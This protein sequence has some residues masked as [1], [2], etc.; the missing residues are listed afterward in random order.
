M[1]AKLV[2]EIKELACCGS[3]EAIAVGEALKDEIREE[4]LIKLACKFLGVH[5]L[6]V[7]ALM[8]IAGI[9]LAK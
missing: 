3:H 4:E 1:K 8:F 7:F 2:K 9:L 5:Y 6:I